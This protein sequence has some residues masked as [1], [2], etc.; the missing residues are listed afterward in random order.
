MVAPELVVVTTAG[1]TEATL[2]R[3]G[4]TIAERTRSSQ[5]FWA[6]VERNDQ[7]GVQQL[8]ALGSL[9]LEAISLSICPSLDMSQ[10]VEWP[11]SSISFLCRL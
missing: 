7:A 5:T 4:T 11:F 1:R 3:R 2:A 10:S 8:L 6:A 9:L